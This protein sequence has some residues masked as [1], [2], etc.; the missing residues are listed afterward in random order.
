MT[1]TKAFVN[2]D[3][4]QLLLI[5]FKVTAQGITLTD[6]NKKKFLRQHFPT[7]TVIYC[8]LDEK[9]TWPVKLEKIAK[10]R[11]LFNLIFALI[12][13]HW[14][15]FFCSFL[16]RIFGVVCKP[17]VNTGSNECHLF[18]ELD[19]DQPAVAIVDFINRYLIPSKLS[20]KS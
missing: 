4:S 3:S 6:L 5:Q 11:Y 12:Y 2:K 18:V 19:P 10:P 13:K 7:N 17:R 15:L 1:N 20:L 16:N 14:L 8:A 9:L